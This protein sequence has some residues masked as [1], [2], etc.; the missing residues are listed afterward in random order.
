MTSSTDACGITSRISFLD[1]SFVKTLKRALELQV[2]YEEAW[3][4]ICAAYNKLDCY[5]EVAAACKQALRYKPALEL[6]RNSSLSSR[7]PTSRAHKSPKTAAHTT[8]ER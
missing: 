8:S 3:N 4:N 7:L 6:A 1:G 2:N 5:E